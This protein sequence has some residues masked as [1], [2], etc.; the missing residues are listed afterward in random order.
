MSDKI[1]VS[2]GGSLSV[3]ERYLERALDFFDKQKYDEALAD[4]EEAIHI[5][6]RNGELYATRG[7][8]HHQMGNMDAAEADFKQALKYDLG[9]WIVYYARAMQA[10]NQADFDAALQHLSQ[11]QKFSGFRPEFFI[12]RAAAY[13]HKGDK[14]HAQAEIDAA[15]QAVD[16]QLNQNPDDKRL[17]STRTEISKWRTAIKDM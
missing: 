5:E 9:Q 6:R 3:A 16:E 17:K 14:S 2:S 10:F 13:Y 15:K 7:Y 11:G 4:L 12:Y 1:R 8:I